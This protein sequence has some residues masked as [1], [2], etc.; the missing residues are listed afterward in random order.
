LLSKPKPTVEPPTES[1]DDTLSDKS[2]I[3]AATIWIREKVSLP[4]V[5]GK[6]TIGTKSGKSY[7][8]AN[9]RAQ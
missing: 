4:K 9:R 7:A 2:G 6:S 1:Y 3:S 5:Q 8:E